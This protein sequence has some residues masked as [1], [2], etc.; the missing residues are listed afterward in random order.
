MY[1]TQYNGR[2]WGLIQTK[3]NFEKLTQK[4]IESIGLPCYLPLIRQVKSKYRISYLPMFRNYLFV[5]WNITDR[6]SLSMCSNIVNRIEIPLGCD[7]EIIKQMESL[8]RLEQLSEVFNVNLQT[9]LRLPKRQLKK[10]NAGPLTGLTGYWK[11]INGK[12]MFAVIMNVMDC[13]FEAT[14]EAPD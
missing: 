6:H 9:A 2:A 7:S 4:Y 14:I 11:G 8:Y 13:Q 5:A 3:P 12:K 10:I 1:F